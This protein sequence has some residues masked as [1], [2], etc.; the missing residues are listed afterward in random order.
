MSTASHKSNLY[1]H[2]IGRLF[3]ILSPV[4]PLNWFCHLAWVPFAWLPELSRV[5]LFLFRFLFIL[6]LNFCCV[7]I[8]GREGS[9][10]SCHPKKTTGTTI[11]TAIIPRTL[12]LATTPCLYTTHAAVVISAFKHFVGMCCHCLFWPRPARPGRVS[13][14]W[15]SFNLSSPYFSHSFIFVFPDRCGYCRGCDICEHFVLGSQY[16][17]CKQSASRPKFCLF[18]SGLFFCHH[19]Y[20]QVFVCMCGPKFHLQRKL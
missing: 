17:Y 4:H 12:T 18:D 8:T 19:L 5:S 6:N 3:G 14:I 1:K 10:P 9:S 20:I 11:K 16:F 2:L 15:A 13:C 7:F